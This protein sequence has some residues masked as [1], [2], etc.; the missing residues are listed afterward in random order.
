MK[1]C[2]NI[3]CLLIVISSAII[4]GVLYNNY[5]QTEREEYVKKLYR[6]Q[7]YVYPRTNGVYYQEEYFDYSIIDE[8]KLY[9]KLM[10][11][12]TDKNK[13]LTLN[14]VKEYLSNQYN[15]DG[16][17]RA[18]IGWDEMYAFEE[19]HWYG[20]EKECI[21]GYEDAIWDA[22]DDFRSQN[23]IDEFIKLSE[24]SIEQLEELVKK[25]ADPTYEIN[26]EVMGY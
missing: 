23:D 24:L 5:K 13:E 16:T 2:I 12:N 14:D 22:I 20:G 26:P 25:V 10:A 1:K 6:A 15:E 8:E 11:Y 21:P 3:I 4:G 19:W 18:E 9:I 7:G 17:L